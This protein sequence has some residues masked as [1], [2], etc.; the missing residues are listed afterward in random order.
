MMNR[1]IN[2]M[3]EDMVKEMVKTNLWRRRR[4]YLVK[5]GKEY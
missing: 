2:D 5:L 1:V 3:V 4:Y